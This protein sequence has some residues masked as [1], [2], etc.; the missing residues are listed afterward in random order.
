MQV[1]RERRKHPRYLLGDSAI[2][3]CN[4]SPGRVRDI[5]LGGL[6]FVYLNGAGEA[7]ETNM[8]DILDG[9]NNFF[10][11]KIPCRTVGETEAVN[12]SRFN[13]IRMIKRTLQF[14]G[15][16]EFQKEKLQDYIDHYALGP[17]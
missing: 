6:A 8:V 16:T 11:E 10:L 17:A 5:S 4:N 7:P 12:D 14:H 15:L 2:A 1:F 13:T 3:V 9:L